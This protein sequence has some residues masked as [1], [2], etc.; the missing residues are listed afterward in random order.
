ML[1]RLKRLVGG[2]GKAGTRA[3]EQSSASIKGKDIANARRLLQAEVKVLLTESK[4]LSQG[5]E[6]ELKAC[7]SRLERATET[8]LKGELRAMDKDL[9]RV[10]QGLQR[11]MLAGWETRQLLD[12]WH[13]WERLRQISD[14]QHEPGIARQELLASEL[15]IRGVQLPKPTPDVPCSVSRECLPASV[16]CPVSR[17]DDWLVEWSVLHKQ[18]VEAEYAYWNDLAA[19]MSRIPFY[20]GEAALA[21][22]KGLK[23][24]HA[25]QRLLDR[26]EGVRRY[27][28]SVFEL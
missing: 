17:E 26:R 21:L 4:I 3:L 23:H 13:E 15:A 8:E 6:R 9:N 19:A 18:A 5:L 7:A 1:R 25:E 27:R 14:G 11:F 2:S 24:A 10:R 28:L 16:P 12:E 20:T 22:Y